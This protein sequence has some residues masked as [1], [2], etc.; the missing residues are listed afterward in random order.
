MRLARGGGAVGARAAPAGP[1]VDAVEAGVRRAARI[2]HGRT[3]AAGVRRAVGV[4]LAIHGDA[5]SDLEAQRAREAA[6]LAGRAVDVL[7]ALVDAALVVHR[8]G[9]AGAR[10]DEGARVAGLVVRTRLLRG[11]AALVERAR[12][13]RG[14]RGQL[15]ADAET[16]GRER[17]ALAARAV[18][19]ALA[20]ARAGRAAAGAAGGRRG[21]RRDA[22]RGAGRGGACRGCADRGEAPRRPAGAR[23]DGRGS[24]RAGARGGTPVTA[25]GARGAG[26]RAAAAPQAGRA[27]AAEGR[28][29]R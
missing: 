2:E 22:R 28:G 10:R 14:R 15:Q 18:G 7:G 27:S 5:G 19:I 23:G 29:D 16:A 9:G 25:A 17:D 20:I 21:R 26:G 12:A 3:D 11:Q 8:D 1:R 4:D 24:A 13:A 6:D